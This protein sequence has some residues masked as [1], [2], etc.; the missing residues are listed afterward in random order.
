[1]KTATLGYLLRPVT[2]SQVEIHRY[3][4]ITLQLLHGP[5]RSFTLTLLQKHDALSP[6]AGLCYL[7]L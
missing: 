6:T 4:H 3:S 1:M 7:L 2:L 5:G